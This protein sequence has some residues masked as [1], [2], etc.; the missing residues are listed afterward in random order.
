MLYFKLYDIIAHEKWVEIFI[1]F[2]VF[3][4][5]FPFI[6]P[7]WCIYNS[8]QWAG[9]ADYVKLLL[10]SILNCHVMFGTLRKGFDV[11]IPVWDLDSEI[12]FLYI[13]SDGSA[14]TN[15]FSHHR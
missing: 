12:I 1:N 5:F 11:Y 6:F 10:N 8:V 4:L 2:P 3:Y 14:L 15:T 9:P 7:L 13:P